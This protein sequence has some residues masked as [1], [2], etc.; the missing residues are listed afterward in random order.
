MAKNIKKKQKKN[1]KKQEEQLP[2]KQNPFYTQWYFLALILIGL[3][4][5]VY[6]PVLDFDFTNW[7]DPTY[8]TENLMIRSLDSDH[9][10]EMFTKPVSLNYHP[11]TMISLAKDYHIAEMFGEASPENPFPGLNPAMYHFTNLLFHLLNTLLVFWFIFLL[12][13]NRWIAFGTALLFAIHPVHIESVAWISERKD[14]LYTFFYLLGLV[15]Y[16]KYLANNKMVYYI[17][18]FVFFVFSLLSKGVA[19]S[20]PVL[21]FGID[22][23]TRRKN[24]LKLILE[25]IPLLIVAVA[26][27]LAAIRIQAEGAIAKEGVISLWQ[28]LSFASYGFFMYLARFFAPVKLSAF[29]PYPELTLDQSLPL[30]FQF[31]FPA[32]ILLFAFVVWKWKKYRLLAFSFFFYFVTIALVLQFIPVGRAIMADRYAYV[33]YIGVAFFLL[34][35]LKNLLEG[36]KPASHARTKYLFIALF[37]GFSSFM[38]YASSKQV[39]VWENSETLWTQVIQNYPQVDVA[40]KNRGNH[41]GSLMQADKAM[42]DYQVLIDRNQVDDQTWGN[43]GNI[44]RMKGRN[45]EALQ[46]YNKQIELAPEKYKGWVNRAIIY[47]ILNQFDKSFPDFEKALELGAPMNVV[48]QSRAYS[49]LNAGQLNEAEQDFMY[50]IKF[51]RYDPKFFE[52]LGVCQYRLKKYNEAIRNFNNAL[53]LNPGNGAFLFNISACYYGL[54]DLSQALDY[55]KRAKQA[56]Y[57]VNEAYLQKLNNSQN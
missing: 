11:L 25:K 50:M 31:F 49:F 48:A 13:K 39:K 38:V 2:Q 29:Y 8:V 26:F 44:H 33:P 24:S 42:A 45:E 1:I 34:Y 47:S 43:I 6:H 57:Q 55:A 30:V 7:D 21:L 27:G 19:V 56:G 15:A 9:L 3:T 40:Y 23:F 20:L 36:L 54:N 46:A 17:L 18:L 37:V 22:F 52:G 14:V 41:Y 4:L 16:M 51:N 35:G 28:K 10:K 12:G 5:A 32:A 53:K